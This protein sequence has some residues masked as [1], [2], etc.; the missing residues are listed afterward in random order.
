MFAQGLRR[1]KARLPQSLLLT[2]PIAQISFWLLPQ[3]R[4]EFEDVIF[5]EQNLKEWHVTRI[6]PQFLGND[7]GGTGVDVTMQTPTSRPITRSHASLASAPSVLLRD[8]VRESQTR[9]GTW[10]L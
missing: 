2:T 6:V 5:R 1:G 4:K 7:N 8:S 9:P 10:H 3:I